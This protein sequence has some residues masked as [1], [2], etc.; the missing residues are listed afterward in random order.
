MEESFGVRHWNDWT[1]LRQKNV[2]FSVDL[3][4]HIIL[5][6]LDVY[7]SFRVLGYF[8]DFGYFFGIRI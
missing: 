1:D 3:R 7:F 6:L 4:E 5:G 8:S 2:R